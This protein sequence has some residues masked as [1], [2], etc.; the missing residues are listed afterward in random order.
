MKRMRLCY[1]LL[2]K[3]GIIHNNIQHY[4]VGAWRDTDL[5]QTDM[6]KEALDSARKSKIYNVNTKKHGH[7]IMI[8]IIHKH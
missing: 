6:Q 8:I 7:W 2:A 5:E 1:Q 3:C 4:T